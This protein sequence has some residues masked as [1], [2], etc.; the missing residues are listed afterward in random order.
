MFEI[1]LHWQYCHSAVN[2][3]HWRTLPRT[4]QLSIT[5]P[6]L[7][8]CTSSSPLRGRCKHSSRTKWDCQVFID[9][10][11]RER[12]SYINLQDT[13]QPKLPV[14][15]RT[16]SIVAT[17]LAA[18]YYSVCELL[19]LSYCRSQCV[20]K[21]WILWRSPSVNCKY[22]WHYFLRYVQPVDYIVVKRYGFLCI[23][24]LLTFDSLLSQ[25]IIAADHAMT[26]SA[27]LSRSRV[28]IVSMLFVS[29]CM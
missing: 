6:G 5:R 7:A 8:T 24:Y 19:Q 25:P 9:S 1:S 11:V 10:S 26:S 22:R 3:A 21:I 14:W 12:D 13:R 28:W 20:I 16:D 2:H 18:G 4:V 29:L 17:S 15:D 27:A 23:V